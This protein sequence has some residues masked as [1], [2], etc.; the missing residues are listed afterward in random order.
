MYLYIYH[1]YIGVYKFIMS[2]LGPIHVIYY[3]DGHHKKNITLSTYFKDYNSHC[4]DSF[5]SIFWIKTF[6]GDGPHYSAYQGNRRHLDNLTCA[7]IMPDLLSKRKN[8]MLLN[9]TDP[10]NFDLNLLD[11]YKRAIQ[12]QSHFFKSSIDTEYQKKCVPVKNLNTILK[13]FDCESSHIQIINL[14]PFKKEIVP[15]DDMHIDMLYE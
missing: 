6:Y 14:R 3:F 8:I 15:I 10:V 2:I 1:V 11:N 13:L 12:N 9:G 5:T 4:S 7:K